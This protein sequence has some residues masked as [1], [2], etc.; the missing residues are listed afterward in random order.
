MF[1][2]SLFI[3][4]I[5]ICPSVC[6][7]LAY[8]SVQFLHSYVLPHVYLSIH[9]ST[10][11][12]W[13]VRLS[14]SEKIGVLLQGQTWAN[15]SWVFNSKC[16]CPRLF[17]QLHSLPKDPNLKM[18]TQP[19][20]PLGYLPLAFSLTDIGMIFS[21]FEW[22]NWPRCL[23]HL[24]NLVSGGAPAKQGEHPWQASIRVQGQVCRDLA[25][26]SFHSFYF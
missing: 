4:L 26:C 18:K 1:I 15:L 14:S 22:M 23:F 17:T 6:L 12:C 16:E 25:F 21:Q 10:C 19:K 3:N 7:Y 8:P 5:L 20:Q 24:S 11:A 13:A 2:L 9:L